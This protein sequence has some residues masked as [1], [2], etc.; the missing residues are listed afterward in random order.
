MAKQSAEN[1]RSIAAVNRTL[2]SI[3]EAETLE[4]YFWVGGK[5]QRFYQSDLGHCYFDLVDGKT[6]IRCMLHDKVRGDIHF[7]L[8]NGLD[9]EVYG[10]VRFYE[11]RAETQIFVRDIRLGD[12]AFAERP[13]IDRLRDAGLYPPQKRL[14]PQRIRRIGC[15]TGRSSRA[16]GD[17]ETAYQSAG[18]RAVLA[19]LSW[20]YVLLEG[21]RAAQSIVDAIRTLDN[22]DSVDAIAIIRG[23]GR[24]D[25][26]AAFESFEVAQAISQ[27]QTFLVTGI[28]HH[29]DQTLSDQVA[30]H[31]ASTP[32][33]AAHFLARHCLSAASDLQPKTPSRAVAAASD[34]QPKTSN[35]AVAALVIVAAVIVIV[36]GI[37]LLRASM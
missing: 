37:I 23:G 15:I 25:D 13:A 11:F 31:A 22:T 4:H 36:L 5:I 3:I 10:D 19:P 1:Q 35:R 12:V 32:T 6:R 28:G 17:F 30:D 7:D 14:P 20:T 34:L 8:Q 18:E 27:C 9:V 26:F 16:I 33:A 29:R 2:R 21:E 24:Y